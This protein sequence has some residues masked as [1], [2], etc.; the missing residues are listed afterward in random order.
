MCMETAIALV[1]L[2][3]VYLGESFDGIIFTLD[4]LDKVSSRV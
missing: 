4:W 1:W 3:E 2:C